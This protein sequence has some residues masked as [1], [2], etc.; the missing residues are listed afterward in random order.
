MLTHTEET[1][2]SFWV[3][4]QGCCKVEPPL[5]GKRMQRLIG[6]VS[7]LAARLS[8]VSNPL[9]GEQSQRGVVEHSQQLRRMSHAQLRMI[10]AQRRIASIMQAVL[11]TPMVS[12]QR[13]QSFS[14]G[15]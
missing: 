15:L 3:S 12:G 14:I 8:D 4:A 2:N 6:L 7:E 9:P 5:T 10:L 1:C 13:K 11:D